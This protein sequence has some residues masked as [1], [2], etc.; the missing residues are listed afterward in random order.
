MTFLKPSFSVSRLKV[1][2][3]GHEAFSCDFHKGVNVI[4]GRNSSGKT[5]IMDLLAFSIGAENIRW[6]PQALLCSSTLTE[7][8]LND[9]PAC[10]RREI[11][12]ET[13]RPL[14]IF[15]GTMNEALESSPSQWETYPFKRTEKTLS[16]SQV[17]LNALDM[18]L[19]QGEGASILTMHQIL[20]VLYADQPSVHSPIFRNDIFDKALTRETVGD[21]LCGIFDDTLYSSLIRLKQV[22]SELS[23]KITELRSIF[24]VLGRSGQSEHIHFIQE[25]IETL[26]KER[27]TLHNKLS[28]LKEESISDRSNK[29]ADRDKTTELRKKL[30]KAKSDELKVIDLI[31]TLEI[32]I[33]DSEMFINELEA[34]HNELCESGIARDY[35][36]NV[37]FQFCPSCLSELHSTPNTGCSL[38]KSDVPEGSDAPQLLRMKN[39]ISVQLKE[40]K[41]LMEH[42]VNKLSE[43]KLSAPT[44][45]KNVQRLVNEYALVS[46]SWEDA[47]EV[48]FEKLTRE[49]GRIDEEIKQAHATQ[50]LNDVIIDLQNKRD[51]LQSEKEQLT[52]LIE[53]LQ[54]K[55]ESRKTDISSA[56]ERAMIRLLKLD[57]PLQTEFIT[58]N[59]INFSFVDNEVYVNGSKNFS[60]SSAVVLRHIFHLALLTSSLEKEYMRLPRFMMLDGIDDGGM[61]KE[62]SH[63]L[64]RIIVE[65]TGSYKHDF[66][67]IYA[68]S[69]I[70]PDYDDTDLIVSRHFNPEDR[71]LNINYTA[72]KEKTLL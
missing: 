66:Q 12:T 62:R 61:E 30:N 13:L 20:R 33:A 72:L 22:E 51:T 52:S 35:F 2:Q 29:T 26:E 31:S 68:T 17:I 25:R 63:N 7:V 60:E 39:E 42:N 59:N 9:K 58:P 37:H 40:S 36:S 5:T 55:E 27:I 16:F 43:L 57:L 23:T 14:S 3:Q 41:H 32:E 47:Y 4:R 70:N 56:I 21:Y 11:A 38:C 54:G 69:E 48:E 67:L 18:P 10:F 8:L 6:K 46:R 45:K 28:V 53:S 19:A 71:S 34:R 65:E 1:F 44:L 15:W 24:S 64:Q 49:L 50:K